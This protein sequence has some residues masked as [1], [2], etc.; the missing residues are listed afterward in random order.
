MLDEP[1]TFVETNCAQM[2]AYGIYRA[3]LWGILDAR[4]IPAAD[5]M[6]AAANAKVDD[7]GIVRD[8][9]GAPGFVSSGVSPEGQ[10][11]Y[12][13]MEAAAEAYATAAGRG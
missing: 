10:A 13:L 6:R 1:D 2:T 3:V 7:D 9:A 5:R 12:I 11:F 4:Y 8:V